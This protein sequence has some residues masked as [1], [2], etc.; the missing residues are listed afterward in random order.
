MFRHMPVCPHDLSALLDL[1]KAMI[2]SAEA[3]GKIDKALG[4]EDE[5]ENTS[6]LVDSTDLRLPGGYTYLGQ[7]IDHD[8]TFDPVSSLTRKN[9]PNALTDFPA[10]RF[11]LDSLYGRGPADQPYMYESD[12]LR[13]HLGDRVGDQLLRKAERGRARDNGN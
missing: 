11:D 10:P 8:I 3:D 2:Q 6:T 5:D 7:F 9:D 1:G 4:V 13:L 12:G